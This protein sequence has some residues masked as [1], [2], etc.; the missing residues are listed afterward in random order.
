M[1]LLLSPSQQNRTTSF[2]PHKSKTNL[3]FSTWLS[4]LYFTVKL[5][6]FLSDNN[7]GPCLSRQKKTVY[8]PHHRKSG[9]SMHFPR[10]RYLVLYTHILPVQVNL[11]NP[12]ELPETAK[13]AQTM[14]LMPCFFTNGA[15]HK[16]FACDQITQRP[17]PCNK[18]ACCFLYQSCEMYGKFSSLVPLDT[19]L[20]A[21][22]EST[23]LHLC[24][25]IPSTVKF[26]SALAIWLQKH[27]FNCHI[28]S[29]YV[30]VDSVYV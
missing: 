5:S 20:D 7:S 22:P 14:S 27:I 16:S 30:T 2:S 17:W 4:R 28:Q 1:T 8:L 13:A 18:D 24:A 11:N 6:L 23:A 10:L 26:F 21:L 12:L 19:L 3:Y 25:S 29:S 9:K 15:A